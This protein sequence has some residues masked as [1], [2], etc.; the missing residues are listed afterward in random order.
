MLK[1][2]NPFQLPLSRT[3][4]PPKR[5]LNTQFTSLPEKETKDMLIKYISHLTLNFQFQKRPTF[6]FS[7]PFF[8][9]NFSPFFTASAF[10]AALYSLILTSLFFLFF[11]QC[12]DDIPFF[13]VRHM[14]NYSTALDSQKSTN[15]SSQCPFPVIVENYLSRPPLLLRVNNFGIG[16]KRGRECGRRW[17]RKRN[18]L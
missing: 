14:H 12:C 9:V 7:L 6:F 3:S 15:F 5:L 11:F 18:P 1:V 10:L 2:F 4:F 8:P 13:P 17:R 16:E